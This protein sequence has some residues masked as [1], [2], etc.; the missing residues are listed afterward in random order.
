MYSRILLKGGSKSI[1]KM[2]HIFWYYVQAGS[3]NQIACTTGN[4]NP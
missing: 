4:Y 1:L 3:A 2:Q